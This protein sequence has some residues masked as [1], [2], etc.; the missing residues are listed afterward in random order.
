M[1][2]YI[3]L[4]PT[5]WI[6]YSHLP[7]ELCLS[8]SDTDVLWKTQP[9]ERAKVKIFSKEMQIPRKQQAYGKP[10]KFSGVLHESV[11]IPLM[12][13]KYIDYANELEED[14]SN[15]VFNMA[16]LNWYES[17]TEYIGYHSDDEAQMVKGSNIYCFSFGATRD[18]LL[19]NKDTKEVMKIALENNTLVIMGGDCQKTHKHSIPKRLKIK[20]YRISI[21]LRKFKD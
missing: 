15:G 3:E 11:H 9:D 17:G 19:K 10:Y 6:K 2:T 13:Q 18:F 16:L 7:E 1:S 8:P 14:A 21:T 20:D 12:I 4:T 5:S